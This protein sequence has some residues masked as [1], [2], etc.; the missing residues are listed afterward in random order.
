MI[1]L[2][3]NILIFSHFYQCFFHHIS[4]FRSRGAFQG[5]FPSINGFS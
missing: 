5:T 1:C 2:F 3:N 4:L